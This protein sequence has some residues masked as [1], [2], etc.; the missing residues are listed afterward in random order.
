MQI[1]R[2]HRLFFP[3]FRSRR[4]RRFAAT[5][6]LTPETRILAVGGT[7]YNWKTIDCEAR[8]TL[9]NV[10]FR[11]FLVPS[12]MEGKLTLLLGDGRQ[13]GCADGS[14][15]ICYSNS[16]IEHLSKLEN[17]KRFASESRR[18][19]RGVWVQTPARCFF[20]E[21]HLITPFIHYLPRGLQRR[22][23]RNFTLWGWMTRPTQERVDA[24]LNEVRLMS[25]REMKEL[26]PD[27]RI[28]RERFLGW[29]KAYIAVRDC[30]RNG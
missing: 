2:I 20:V 9:L 14:F 28:E 19:G 26:F 3:Y 30:P 7:P 17:Q 16:V 4:M 12:E 8:V 6:R 11:R 29:T 5:F 21:P 23:L 25:Y 27:C 1:Q 15:D 10:V 18:V 24:F 13:L 22:M